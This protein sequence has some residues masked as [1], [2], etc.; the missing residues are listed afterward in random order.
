VQKIRFCLLV[1]FALTLLALSGCGHHHEEAG[2][3]VPVQLEV[4]TENIQER[5]G[6]SGFIF[7]TF[8]MLNA[9]FLIIASCVALVVKEQTFKKISDTVRTVSQ[10]LN[11]NQ[12]QDGTLL[13]LLGMLSNAET[14]FSLG[15]FGMIVGLVVAYFGA[16]VAT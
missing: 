13:K 9:Y 11:P 6:L 1:L 16:W 7:G 15:T 10:M 14:R 2:T 12:A 8:L 3:G 5:V 4:S